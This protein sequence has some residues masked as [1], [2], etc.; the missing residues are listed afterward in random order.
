M[1][2]CHPEALNNPNRN[3][4]HFYPTYNAVNAETKSFVFTYIC[5][6][7]ILGNKDGASTLKS[8]YDSM[9]IKI[10]MS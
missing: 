10:D 9:T 8:I 3:I 7:V 2:N 1:T 5:A 6:S 4:Q